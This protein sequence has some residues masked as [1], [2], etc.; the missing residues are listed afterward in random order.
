[1]NEQGI[2]PMTTYLNYY[3]HLYTNLS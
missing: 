1:M 3:G 2:D